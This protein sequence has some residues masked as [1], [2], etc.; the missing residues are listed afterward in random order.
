MITRSWPIAAAVDGKPV[1][2]RAQFEVN[3]RLL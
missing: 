2:V 1:N 3:F